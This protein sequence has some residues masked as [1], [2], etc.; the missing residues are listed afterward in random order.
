MNIRTSFLGA[1]LIAASVLPV[2]SEISATGGRRE[3]GSSA[4]RH[5]NYDASG[6]VPAAP[7]IGAVTSNGGQVVAH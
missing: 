4:N 6:T 7:G 2:S 5:A 1:L 3:P